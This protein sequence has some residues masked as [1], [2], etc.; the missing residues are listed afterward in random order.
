VER[1]TFDEARITMGRRRWSRLAGLG[2]GVAMMAGAGAAAAS[3][4]L[5][6]PESG[7]EQVGRGSAWLAR[8]DDPLAVYY[9]PA[10]MAFQATSVHL[11][12][13][14]M[15]AN[16][17]YT[18]TTIDPATG[19]QITVPID[20]GIPSPLLPGQKYT[21]TDPTD[22]T[23]LPSGT[24]C[25]NSPPF[26]NPQIAAV[27]RL[28]DRVAIGLALVAPHAAGKATWPES[29]TYTNSFGIQTTQ[30][31]PQ[32]YMLVSS[33]ALIVFPTVSVAYAPLDNLSFGAG[34][35]WGIGTADFV[36]FSE[37]TSPKP[38]ATDVGDHSHVDARAEFKAKDLF[39]PG[40]VL[41]TL[42][43]PTPNLDVS[44][45]FKWQDALKGSG[46][47]TIESAY[48]KP[49][50]ARNDTY[51]ADLTPPQAKGCN[52]TG[53][54]VGVGEL[55]FQI[56][57]EA[58]VGL[59]YHMLRADQSNKPAWASV[60][61]R[62]VRDPL[63]EDLFDIEVDF[64]YA[65]NQSLQDL[66]LT[67]QPGVV[68]KDGS[69]S[70]VGQVPKNG[71]IPHNWKDVFG[72]RLGGD[73]VVIPN[74]LTLR[75]GGFFEVAGQD[76]A[77]LSLDFDNAWKSGVS[78]GA[79]VRVGAV[80]IAIGYQHTF[81]GTLDNGGKG[82]IYALS[83]DASGASGANPQCN[84]AAN[85]AAGYGQGCFRSWQ[86]INGGSLTASLN[87]LGLSGTMRF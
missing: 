7:V 24:V 58:K 52:V 41:S 79:K 20:S 76:A 61:G 17:C 18:R 66:Q 42:W 8:A 23:V 67:F 73:F 35:I 71:N 34:F 64:T 62:R 13:Q 5:D 86:P 55:K 75:T 3:S 85:K 80:D 28:S 44:A 49:N 87:E 14:L 15:M 38:L 69:A 36:N 45:W 40:F 74:R 9:N 11:G 65:N 50:G 78:G 30:P 26:P 1:V 70:G 84:T 19:K 81:Y 59:R 21:P 56:P 57:M 83:G 51:C 68:I 48:W 33:N 16:K 10:A 82:A 43:S 2:A 32:R 12:A 6:S 53:P 27:F 29:L 63:S 60:P 54:K 46:D 22:K 31:S 47:L 4:G 37:T 25:A 77:Y 72:V 39:I